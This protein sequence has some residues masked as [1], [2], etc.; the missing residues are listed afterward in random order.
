[1]TKNK[2]NKLIE[3]KDKN[4]SL[5][6]N[7]FIKNYYEIRDINF[8]NLIYI[9]LKTT[10]IFLLIVVLNILLNNNEVEFTIKFPSLENCITTVEI[11]MRTIV[12]FLSIIFSFS[13][14]SFQLFNKYFGRFAFYDFFKK[15]H[16]KVM[17]TL[18]ILNL[19]FLIYTFNY[20]KTCLIDNHFRTYGKLIFIES[21]LFSLILVISIFPV[22]I[23]LLSSSQSRI[24]LKRLFNSITDESILS[25]QSF[26]SEKIDEEDY[27][28]NSFEIIT[29]I[30]S[31][32]IK[33]FDRSS[34]EIITKNI[35]IKFLEIS[36][37][38]KCLEIKR[39]LYSK[40]RDVLE[41]LFSYALKEKNSFAMNK[42]LQARFGI[43][44]EVIL[45]NLIIDYQDKYNGWGFNFDFEDFYNKAFQSNEEIICVEI[46]D[47]YRDFFTEIIRVKFPDTFKFD[48]EKPYENLIET[49]IVSTNYSLIEKFVK[50]SGHSKKTLILKTLSNLFQTLDLII[51]ESNNHNDTKNYLLQVNNRHKE[52]FLKA[53]IED[54]QI[55]NI[56]F[57]NYPYGIATT[58]EFSKLNSSIILKSQ[59]NSFDYFFQK[60]VL[61]NLV[62]NNLEASAFHLI[63]L[64][65]ND[66][67]KSKLLLKLIIEKFDYI[68]GL[69][70]ENDS[71]ERK[72]VYIKLNKYLGYIM[73]GFEQKVDDTELIEMLSNVNSK[74]EY[75]EKFKIE[76]KEI[77]YIQDNSFF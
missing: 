12:V 41:D 65:E 34:F 31:V 17:F 63:N 62:M 27:E 59:L 69:I 18:F 70:K 60:N 39:G 16:L 19:S 22:M 33:D 67:V 7:Y 23:N 57:S 42:I 73:N 3:I 14:L 38:E 9:D 36:K 48:F 35:Y 28:T 25:T 29:E 45:T 64:Y 20:L 46:V 66:K 5:F 26:Y 11:L 43:E 37:D 32:A 24:N 2:S 6:K 52:K 49:S 72:D 76:I 53:L 8:K 21:I 1:M 77:G 44:K 13:L 55:K 58:S 74:F 71:I 56:E 4:W 51:L 40:F 50:S 47:L 10:I 68:R 54:A 30:S 15:S 75:L 61:N